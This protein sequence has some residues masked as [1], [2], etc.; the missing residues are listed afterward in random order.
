MLKVLE[1]FRLELIY[2]ILDIR[3][4]LELR[5]SSRHFKLNLNLI[6]INRLE[7]IKILLS[8]NLK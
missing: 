1:A 2:L 5:A 6:Q 3:F 4:F 7:S 8:L